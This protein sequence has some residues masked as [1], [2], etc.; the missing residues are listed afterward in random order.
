MKFK[1]YKKELELVNELLDTPKFK[2]YEEEYWKLDIYECNNFHTLKKALEYYNLLEYSSWVN[3][4][5]YVDSQKDKKG[6]LKRLRY[7]SA[8]YKYFKS[9]V[10]KSRTVEDLKNVITRYQVERG[11]YA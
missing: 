8:N 2:N 10:S 1:K 9:S 11:V 6:M 4:I 7:F 3:E 5:L